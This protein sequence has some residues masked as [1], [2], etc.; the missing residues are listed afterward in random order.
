[1]ASIERY[2]NRNKVKVLVV[3]A[4][5]VGSAM[6]L[7]NR[8]EK[9][10]A[11]SIQILDVVS[12]YEI[13]E[14]DLKDV[15]LIISS[16]SLSSVMFLTPVINVSVF[17][18]NEDVEV[19]RQYLT[20]HF[21]LKKDKH[22]REAMAP[23]K[24]KKIIQQV[25]S[26]QRIIVFKETVNK[27]D[28]LQRMVSLLDEGDAPGFV[29]QFLEQIQLRENYSSVVFGDVLAFPHPATPLSLTEQIVVGIC[30]KP[31]AWNPENQ[32]IHFVFLLSPSRAHNTCL[33]YISPSLVSFVG[34]P[35]LQ[36]QLMQNPTYPEL[37]KLF[38]P[39]LEDQ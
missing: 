18:S 5:G 11:G 16:V 7:K 29:D 3:C 30:H 9:E 21:F 12:Y 36:K 32:N 22:I 33:K 24:A 39:L 20:E 28:L 25:F 27:A 35:S 23:E 10:F 31:I 2:S 34:N 14:E 19:V 6:M 8:L 1:M 26:E 17:L 15:D 37:E 4:T 38:I 13:T